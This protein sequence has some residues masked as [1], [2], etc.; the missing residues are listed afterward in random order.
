MKTIIVLQFSLILLFE[1]VYAGNDWVV[2]A[3]FNYSAFRDSD[4][5]AII[6]YSL[7]FS[8]EV[9]L[10][11]KI[12][13]FPDFLISSQGGMLRNKPVWNDDY[14]R[15]LDSY[16]FRVAIQLIEVGLIMSYQMLDKPYKIFFNLGPSWRIGLHDESHSFDR[17]SIYDEDNP[18]RHKEFENYDFNYLLGDPSFINSSGGAINLGTTFRF[19]RINFEI[20]YSYALHNIGAFS[21]LQKVKK[22]SHTLHFFVGLQI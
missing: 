14:E 5:E 9:A 18:R 12:S 11:D 2:K 19:N 7:G 4:N 13:L 20:R 15:F 1:P 16:S 17:K 22:K 6:N 21:S 10:T 3:G 8:R